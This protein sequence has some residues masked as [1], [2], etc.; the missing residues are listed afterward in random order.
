MPSVLRDLIIL[1]AISPRF[2][3]STRENPIDSTTGGQ[4]LSSSEIIS[5]QYTSLRYLF[6]VL[7]IRV[8]TNS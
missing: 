8:S 6:S 5:S 2:A 7:I 3:I 1:N 4:R